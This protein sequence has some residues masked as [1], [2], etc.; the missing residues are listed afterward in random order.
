MKQSIF[1]TLTAWVLYHTGNMACVMMR[2]LP[3]MPLYNFYQ[4]SMH[5]SIELDKAG[6]VWKFVDEKPGKN[7]E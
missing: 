1:H 5:K 3:W 7:S 4:F 2:Y 6:K